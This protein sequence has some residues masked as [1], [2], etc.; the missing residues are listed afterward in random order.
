MIL[1]EKVLKLRTNLSIEY[2]SSSTY[3][4]IIDVKQQIKI[5]K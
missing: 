5:N 4:P 2:I 1:D 3:V